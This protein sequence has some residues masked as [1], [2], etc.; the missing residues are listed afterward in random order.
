LHQ[1]IT[2]PEPFIE[3]SE[4]QRL[5][6]L[7]QSDPFILLQVNNLINL[8]QN[9]PGQLNYFEPKTTFRFTVSRTF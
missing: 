8:I 5:R 2:A 1:T 9:N 7:A 3:P 6:N 4:I